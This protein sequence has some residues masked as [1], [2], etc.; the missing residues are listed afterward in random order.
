[1]LSLSPTSPS[2]VQPTPPKIPI[3]N[4][5][6]PLRPQ[7]VTL[8]GYLRRRFYSSDP[9]RFLF[10]GNNSNRLKT[11]ERFKRYLSLAPTT[12]I[13]SLPHRH[14]LSSASTL[15]HTQ[16]PVQKMGSTSAL[17]SHP[18]QLCSCG[19]TS[20]G[21]RK[22]DLDLQTRGICSK[23]LAPT[24]RLQLPRQGDYWSQS[25]RWY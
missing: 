8:T 19:G 14:L 21:L 18:Q 4:I 22:R 24:A 5:P 16:V 15:N 6:P 12:D 1:M 25:Q 17:E 23:E 3:Q 20:I 2:R 9:R 13:S 11:F 7:S 10:G